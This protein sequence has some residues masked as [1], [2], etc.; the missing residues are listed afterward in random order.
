M[1]YTILQ[2]NALDMLQTIPDESVRC[3]ITSPPYFGLRSYLPQDSPDKPLEIGTEKQLEDYIDSLVLVFREVR[4]VLTPDGALWLNIADCYNGSGGA[5]GD[6]N[7][8]GKREGQLKYPG[9]KV[10][11]LKPKDLCMVPARVAIALQEDGYWL[12]SD[13]VWAKPSPMPES[14]NDRP[15]KSHEFIFLLT[16]NPQYYYDADAIREPFVTPPHAP[17]NKPR[18]GITK[19]AR[20]DPANDPTRVWGNP[21]GRNKRDV[22]VVSS[23]KRYKGAHFA[24]MPEELV[25]PCVLAG[26]APGDLVLDPFCGSGTVG[27]VALKHGRRFIGIDLVSNYCHM[28]EER[29]QG[30]SANTKEG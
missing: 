15:T 27:A 14:T 7:K 8:G 23:R 17:G 1:D 5:G 3:C 30:I 22:W 29:L 18:V 13:I 26:S 21:L 28:A 10:A 24:T 6:Y 16:K 12:R 11:G 4:R 25:E 20:T 2:G 9:R 19:Q